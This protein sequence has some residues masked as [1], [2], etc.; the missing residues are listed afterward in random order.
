MRILSSMTWLIAL[1]L[2]TSCDATTPEPK[3]EPIVR[4][5]HSFSDPNVVRVTHGDFDWNL[6]FEKQVL[7]GAVTWTLERGDAPETAE[8][9]LDT[10]NLEIETVEAGTEGGLRPV[11]WQLDPLDEVRGRALRIPVGPGDDRVR[12]VYR[13]Q[14]GDSGLQWLAPGQTAGGQHPFLFSQAQAILA[15]TF[16][17][18]QDTPGVRFTFTARVRVP[19]GLK[20]AM[21]AERLPME[22]GAFRFR[23]PQP[24]PSYLVAICAGD[25]EFR[26]LGAR[27]GVWAEP[28]VVEAAAWEFA[29]TERMVE[30]AEKLYGPYRWDRYEIMVLPP[31]FP[32][33]GMENPRLTFATPTVLAGDRSLVALVAHE[34]AHSWS[35]N[36]VTNATWADLWMNEGFTVYLERRIMESVYG[37]ERAAMEANLGKEDLLEDMKDLA[38]SDTVLNVDLKGRNPDDVFSNVPYEKGYLFLRLLE[39]TY[40]RKRFDEFLQ[41]WFDANAFKSRTTADFEAFLDE[42]LFAED[43]GAR[44]RLGV[45]AWLHGPGLPANAPES[46]TDALAKAEAEAAA[47][48]AGTREA[49]DL[50]GKDWITHQWLRFL[51]S[52]PEQVPADRMDALD[53]AWNLSETGNSEIRCQWLL[54]AIRSDY[55]PAWPALEAFLTSQGRR[56]FLKPLYTALASTPAGKERA[57]A[58]YAKARPGYHAVSYGTIDKILGVD[59]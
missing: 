33:G 46:P 7:A 5:P 2:L 57:L 30:T 24:I 36:L 19:E 17:P 56:K 3:P 53:E 28:S 13:T 58:I 8:V 42:H 14:P 41:A 51:R 52:L 43:P 15:R 49:K 27:T 37:P 50:P 40:G 38:P 25:L 10:R 48:V 55:A 16:L 21:G 18:C 29:D 20:A 12:I 44:G 4:D 59:E 6:D 54:Q 26:E 22:D 47:F 1:L 11:I 31:S 23:M 45:Q 9:V 35:G 39:Q 32:F 34:L